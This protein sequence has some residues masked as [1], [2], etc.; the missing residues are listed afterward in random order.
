[1]SPSVLFF[2][3]VF[4][5][6]LCCLAG[7]RSW[8]CSA[9]PSAAIWHQTRVIGERKGVTEGTSVLLS[10]LSL[11]S[12]VDPSLWQSHWAQQG[13][14]ISRGAKGES[15]WLC[16]NRCINPAAGEELGVFFMQAVTVTNKGRKK[17]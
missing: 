14:G 16:G 4:G 2:W 12:L 1:M 17:Q 15:P 13:F 6:I 8:Q 5:L 11:C 3:G 10:V 9:L 7:L